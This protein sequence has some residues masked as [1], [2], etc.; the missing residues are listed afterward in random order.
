MNIAANFTTTL[1][2]INFILLTSTKSVCGNCSKWKGPRERNGRK[3]FICMENSQGFCQNK[4]H[5]KDAEGKASTLTSPLSN[6][7]CPNW[8][9]AAH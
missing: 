3:I 1:P 8:K 5:N 2:P 6:S 9:F 4:M 7:G